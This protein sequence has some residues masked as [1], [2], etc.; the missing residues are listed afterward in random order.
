MGTQVSQNTSRWARRLGV[1]CACLAFGLLTACSASVSVGSDTVDSADDVNVGECVSVADSSDGKVEATKTDCDTTDAFAFYVAS[2]TATTSQCPGQESRLTF[3]E[4][5]QQ[6]CLTPNMAQGKCYEVP[7]GGA[8]SLTDF[9]AV[10]CGA[11]TADGTAVVEVVTRSNGTV[12]CDASLTALEF[13]EP[14]P[15]GYC[16]RVS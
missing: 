12:T 10:D 1:A 4:G 8:G 16:L 9:K 3:E 14:Q 11:T 2:T 13:T 6:L 5:D 15:L 7:S